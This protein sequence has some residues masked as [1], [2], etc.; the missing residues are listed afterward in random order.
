MRLKKAKTNKNRAINFKCLES[1]FNKIKQKASIYTDGNVSEYVLFA[2]L[3]FV[4][5]KDDFEEEQNEKQCKKSK[6]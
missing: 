6:N 5:S 4:P 1:D 2:A 3:N